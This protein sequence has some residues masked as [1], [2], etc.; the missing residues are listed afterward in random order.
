MTTLIKPIILTLNSYGSTFQVWPRFEKYAIG[1]NC[2]QLYH[3]DEDGFVEPFCTLTSALVDLNQWPEQF[4]IKTYAE[5]EG[6][7]EQLIDQGF[8][9]QDSLYD[10]GYQWFPSCRLTKEAIETMTKTISEAVSKNP[11][12]AFVLA[13]QITQIAD[14]AL[15]SLHYTAIEPFPMQYVKKEKARV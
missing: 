15:H 4:F 10:N 14:F 8:L 3:E 2:I 9:E 12:N 11:E 13:N 6:F 5:N 7:L 1:Q